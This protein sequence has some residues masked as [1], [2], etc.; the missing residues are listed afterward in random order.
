MTVK[1]KKSLSESM[2]AMVEGET[3]SDYRCSSCDQKVEIEKKVAVRSMPNMLI[4]HL[5]RI[6]FDFEKM[7]NVKV[8]DRWEFPD[9]INIKDYMVD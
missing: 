9:M 2:E 8:N 4:V 1:N 6:I 3:I 7:R 5:N